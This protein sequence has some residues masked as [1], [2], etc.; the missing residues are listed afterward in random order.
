MEN[1][2]F[3]DPFIDIVVFVLSRIKDILFTAVD[4]YDIVL[5]VV[6]S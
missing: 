6:E 4:D 3:L 2:V 5:L 1:T